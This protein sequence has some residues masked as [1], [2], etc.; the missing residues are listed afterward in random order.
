MGEAKRRRERQVVL[1]MIETLERWSFPP[2]QAEADL[3]K[4]IAK[5]P[6]VQVRR[7]PREELNRK[8]M[9]PSL[10][11]HNAYTFAK[12]DPEGKTKQVTG[13]WPGEG[14]YV[15]HS[16]VEHAGLFYC[17]TPKSDEIP[18]IFSFIPDP[19][20]VWL[21]EGN[22]KKAYRNGFKIDRGLRTDPAET[23]RINAIIRKR[24]ESGM[25]PSKA[26]TPPF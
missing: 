3:V 4:K 15:L 16:V 17:V 2:T 5:L 24:V 22:V 12:T 8:G 18:E 13:W 20:I 6:V 19:Q 21:Q 1:A 23:I 25:Q 9:L 26:A 10:C 7:I 14:N 11:H